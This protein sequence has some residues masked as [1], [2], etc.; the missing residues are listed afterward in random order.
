M[1]ISIIGWYGTETLGDRA[2][3]DGILKVISCIDSSTI[4]KIGSLYPFLTERTIYEDGDFLKESIPLSQIEI[5]EIKDKLC[6]KAEIKASDL[7]IIGGGPLMDLEELF[8][9]KSCVDEAGN[10]NIPTVVMG[11]GLGPLQHSSYI[12]TVGEIL[13]KATKVSFRDSLSE[14]YCKN[15]YNNVQTVCLGDPAVIS[16]ENYRKKHM[17]CNNDRVVVNFREYTAEYGGMN[18]SLIDIQCEIISRL[19]DQYDEVCL[20]PMHTFDIGGD[21]RYYLTKLANKA[22]KNNIKVVHNP[23]NLKGLYEYCMDAFGCV[24]MR[25]HSV[26]IQTILNGNNL[27]MNYTGKNT[28][29]I[30]GFLNDIDG[31]EFYKSRMIDVHEMDTVNVDE[32]IEKLRQNEKF[33]YSYSGMLEKYIDF[34]KSVI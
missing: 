28:G 24:G 16:I 6:R 23:M 21:D 19:S 27:I 14:K 20:I 29:K 34:I 15:L 1:V 32:Y 5:F 33:N 22:K 13:G 31:G 7:V 30:K 25:Y 4:I 10:N 12:Q 26:V 2:I 8:L 11:C 17:Y 3:L 18:S 9:L